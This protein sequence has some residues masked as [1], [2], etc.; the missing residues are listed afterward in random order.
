MCSEN[1]YGDYIFCEKWEL[2]HKIEGMVNQRY[3]TNHGQVLFDFGTLQAILKTLDCTK[4]D[5][6]Y[7]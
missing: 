2:K 6:L 3:T 4:E 5:D 1:E 7:V